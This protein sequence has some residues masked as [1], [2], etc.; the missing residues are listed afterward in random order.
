MPMLISSFMLSL[1][2]RIQDTFFKLV[3]VKYGGEEVLRKDE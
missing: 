2:F 3:G 1:R